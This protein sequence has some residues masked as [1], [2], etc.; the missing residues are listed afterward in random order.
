MKKSVIKTRRTSVHLP[1]NYL[2]AI[3]TI[4]TQERIY[5]SHQIQLGLKMYFE[6]YRDLLEAKGVNV[7]E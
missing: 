3:E 2:Q 4:R 6:K 1:L 5:G 7:W